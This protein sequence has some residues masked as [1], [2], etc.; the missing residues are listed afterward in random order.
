MMLHGRRLLPWAVAVVVGCC[1]IGEGFV[2]WSLPKHQLCC[3]PSQLIHREQQ[4]GPRCNDLQQRIQS[5][6]ASAANLGGGVKINPL[7][8][9]T[10]SV[11]D[12]L[13]RYRVGLVTTFPA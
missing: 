8:F 11:V 12:N 5:I 1:Q 9:S 6:A 10:K 13:N 7:S 2:R 3:Q 4:N